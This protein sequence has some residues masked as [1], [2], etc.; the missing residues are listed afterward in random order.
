[1]CWTLSLGHAYHG[2]Q[3]QLLPLTMRTRFCSFLLASCAVAVATAQASGVRGFTRSA[4]ST[5]I[6]PA[7]ANELTRTLTYVARRPIQ[8]WIRTSGTVDKTGKM[9]TT[10]VRAPDSDLIKIGQRTRTFTVTTRTR[11]TQGY[12]S[13]IVKQAGGA[14]VEIALQSPIV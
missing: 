7:Q 5:E 9:L 1:Q 2:Q 14:T 6:T 10:F 8:T 11:M 13:K 3:G 4:P 12:V